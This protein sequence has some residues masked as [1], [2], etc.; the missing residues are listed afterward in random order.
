[1]REFY[2]FPEIEQFRQ[3]VLNVRHR[4][5]FIDLDERGEPIYD[6]SKEQPI[7]RFR[8]TVKCHGTNSGIIFNGDD[9]YFQSRTQIIDIGND[10]A[11]FVGFFN[12]KKSELLK[13]KELLGPTDEVVK[14]WGEWCGKSIQKGVAICDLDKMFVIFAIKIGEEWIS[15]EKMKLIRNPEIKVMNILDY[16]TYQIDIDFNYPEK[17]LDE[18][19]RIALEIEAECP[20]GKSFGVTGVGEGVVF[21][22]IDEDWKG[23]RYWMKVKG[24]KHRGTKNKKLVTVDAEKM[25]SVDEFVAA[26][27]TE[28]R[29]EQGIDHLRLQGLGID[30]KNLGLFLKW[31]SG[32]IIKEESD[33]LAKS[34][35]T[36]KDVN[37]KISNIAKNWFFK[38]EEEIIFKK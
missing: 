25:N 36:E 23:S 38:K 15:D 37:S 9:V 12:N 24:E 19:E 22:T 7:L 3:V 1:M 32:D 28:S 2:K 21:M 8:G 31:I 35:L 33:T 10:N 16:P 4:S 6:E 14:I 29:L 13:L 30:R 5:F 17:S 18:L 27:L 20:V 11:G 26:V 34:N